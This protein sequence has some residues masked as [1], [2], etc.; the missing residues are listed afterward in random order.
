MK[1]ELKILGVDVDYDYDSDEVNAL[2]E[3]YREILI[4]MANDTTIR[5]I[6]DTTVD[7]VENGAAYEEVKD[8]ISSVYDK[9]K[10]SRGTAMAILWVL[11]ANNFGKKEAYRESG[12]VSG[13]VWL[14][15][16]DDKVRDSHVEADGQIVK[17]DEK[18]K[19]NGEYLEYPGDPSGSAGNI[20]GCRCT[21][22]GVLTT[23]IQNAIKNKRARENENLRNIRDALLKE[24]A[25]GDIENLNNTVAKLKKEVVDITRAKEI[26][27]NINIK[28]TSDKGKEAAKGVS[29]E[30]TD[31]ILTKSTILSNL[32]ENVKSAEK[33]I[34][35]TSAR[36]DKNKDEML[37]EMDIAKKTSLDILGRAH[38]EGSKILEKA[39]KEKERTLLFAESESAKK[40]KGAEL[41]A[42]NIV[43][44]AN[45]YAD[46][47]I[48]ESNKRTDESLALDMLNSDKVERENE[49]RT[50]E[51]NEKL[52]VSE[53]ESQKL[54]ASAKRQTLFMVQEA[55][56][57]AKEIADK[58]AYDVKKSEKKVG[59]LEGQIDSL[60][61]VASEIIEKAKK[62]ASEIIASA[63]KEKEDELEEITKLRDKLK[64]EE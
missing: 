32:K 42:E 20:I 59:I 11:I 60:K 24:I 52:N 9:A 8:A 39:D 26:V 16:K 48:E 38:K 37:V 33:E 23:K 62:K 53:K 40:V 50:A 36:V 35:I 51:S 2:L 4:G 31:E 64:D 46:K 1:E 29:G 45:K 13:Q 28:E 44:E 6:K 58:G 61:V 30:L 27:S 43:D 22:Q 63:K 18:F 34:D 5:K 14:T 15:A 47:T 10:N 19:V 25:S 49:K 17:L 56:K 21:T 7:I 41:I 54:T 55:E 12:V 3:K 57:Q